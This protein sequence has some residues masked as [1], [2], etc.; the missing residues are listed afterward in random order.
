M[1]I[2][3]DPGHMGG[4]AEMAFIEKKM[5]KIHKEELNGFPADILFNEGNLTLGT[6]LALKQKLEDAGANVMMTRSRAGETA[7]GI[8][9][10][11]WLKSKYPDYLIKNAE[12]KK[13]PAKDVEFWLTK[14]SPEQIFH[15]VFKHADLEERAR[16]I[17]EYR[18]D[19]TVFI[20]YNVKESNEMDPQ[21]YIHAVKDNFNMAFIPGAYLNHELDS[22]ENR[23]NFLRHLVT[24]D[25]ERSLQLSSSVL[26]EFGRLTEVPAVPRMMEDSL[27]YL[28]KNS[29][30]TS[31]TGVY[32]RN[33][34][35]NERVI[36]PVV[37]GESLNQD[38]EKECIRLFSID[39]NVNGFRV[40]PRVKEIAEA[41]FLGII[42]YVTG[43]TE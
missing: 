23:M 18:P 29:M 21:G 43:K 5:V 30:R 42:T 35:L 9:F 11:E 24:S 16:I 32:A 20:H 4:T 39:A 10:D 22:L 31:K 14:A 1:K 37:F 34:A 2:A 38:N 36:G 19:F 7:F 25:I 27:K 26:R 3:L 33:L 41:Y 12:R 13:I 17:N 6:G 8:T 28:G 40:S 15:K